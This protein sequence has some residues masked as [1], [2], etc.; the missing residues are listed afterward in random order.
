M[1]YCV[2]IIAADIY[3]LTIFIFRQDVMDFIR[4]NDGSRF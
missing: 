3:I 4:N 2:E 1:F